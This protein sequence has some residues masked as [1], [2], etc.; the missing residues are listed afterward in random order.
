MDEETVL[1]QW[2]RATT[3]FSAGIFILA[4]EGGQH[5]ASGLMKDELI[6]IV[7]G[8]PGLG[9]DCLDGLRPGAPS[10]NVKKFPDRS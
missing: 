7:A 8:S 5:V 1:P 6:D 10:V 3:N 2:L 9:E 4:H